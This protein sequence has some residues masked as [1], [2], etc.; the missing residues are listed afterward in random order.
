MFCESR[1]IMKSEHPHAMLGRKYSVSVSAVQGLVFRLLNLIA[2]WQ[3]SGRKLNQSKLSDIITENQ[4]LK[5]LYLKSIFC[6]EWHIDTLI[7]LNS[8]DTL[9]I[10]VIISHLDSTAE[11]NVSANLL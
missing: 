5:H 10:I 9:N 2:Y 1:W 7:L 3:A 6:S 4:S 11:L 8:L